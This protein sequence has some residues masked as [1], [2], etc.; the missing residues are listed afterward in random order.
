MGFSSEL[1]SAI[2]AAICRSDAPDDLFAIPA[3]VSPQRPIH[4]VQI[5]A[6]RIPDPADPLQ[7]L[8]MLLVPWVREGLPEQ[9][10]PGMPPTF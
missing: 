10:V 2:Y 6:L 8:C 3:S 9:V 1:A 7:H 4:L 5:E